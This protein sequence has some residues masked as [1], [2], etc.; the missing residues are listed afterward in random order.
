MWFYF[1]CGFR[2][3]LWMVLPAE[4]AKDLLGQ[5]L[6]ETLQLLVK[7]YARV[8]ASYKR[9]LQIRYFYQPFNQ[10]KTQI[11]IIYNIVPRDKKLKTLKCF[12]F[13][14][15]IA[16]LT[17][18]ILKIIFLCIFNNKIL[19][20]PLNIHLWLCPAFNRQPTQRMT[21]C[22]VYFKYILLSLKNSFS[23]FNW[24]ISCSFSLALYLRCD[25]AA[26]L[27]YVE[28][29]MW[30][31]CESPEALVWRKPSS[32]NS[33]LAGGCDWPNQIHSLCDQLLTVLAIVT[34]PVSL[35]Y[36]YVTPAL[37]QLQFSL[38]SNVVKLLLGIQFLHLR[39]SSFQEKKTNIF[40]LIAF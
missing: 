36:R 7:R 12:T 18:V 11:W 35:L 29:L 4:L 17:S 1:L 28:H 40:N 16:I 23:F 13:S 14:T 32:E 25:I 5:V 38:T 21:Q 3:D 9:H 34:A 6:M 24:N 30:S 10:H 39:S 19:F 31:L 26:V 8:R 22:C 20:Y 33:I 15:Y 2:S 27:L 37:L